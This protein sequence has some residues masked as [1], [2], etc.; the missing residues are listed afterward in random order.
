MRGCA[1]DFSGVIWYSI[2]C[3][4][5]YILFMRRV[6]VVYTTYRYNIHDRKKSNNNN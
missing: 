2:H 3:N 6:H 5:H 1:C 4:L